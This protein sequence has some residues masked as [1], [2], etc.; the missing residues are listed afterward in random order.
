MEDYSGESLGGPYLSQA[1]RDLPA[2]IHR[3]EGSVTG[4]PRDRDPLHGI[5]RSHAGKPPPANPRSRRPNFV[6]TRK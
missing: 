1:A 3:E 2:P 5:L 4:F 6:F